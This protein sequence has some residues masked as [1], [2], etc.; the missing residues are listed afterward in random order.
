M[1]GRRVR[2]AIIACGVAG[3]LAFTVS[4]WQRQFDPDLPVAMPAQEANAGPATPE[5]RLSLPPKPA[6]RTT[7]AE[8]PGNWLSDND[9]PAEVMRNEWSGTTG[10][11]LVIDTDGKV[12]RCAVTE[13]SGHKILD[14][15]TCTVLTRNARFEPARDADGVPVRDTYNGR[16][17]WRLPD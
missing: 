16:V 3:L 15:A 1:D 13:S 10:F 5:P 4:L 7:P 17:T 9:Y 8:S 14:E 6:T 11:Q 2:E 12:E